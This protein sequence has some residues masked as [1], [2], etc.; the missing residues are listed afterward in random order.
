MSDL[1]TC[2][3][4]GKNPLP[5]KDDLAESHIEAR[6]LI[7]KSSN[8]AIT[9]AILHAIPLALALLFAFGPAFTIAMARYTDK[10]L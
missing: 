2:Y 6:V 10:E 7:K 8:S 9:P 1:Q 5:K 3:S 4:S